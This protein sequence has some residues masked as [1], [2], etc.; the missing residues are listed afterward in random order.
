MAMS[1]PIRKGTDDPDFFA[2]AGAAARAGAG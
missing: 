1:P 2:G